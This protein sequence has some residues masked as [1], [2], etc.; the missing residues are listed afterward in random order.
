MPDAPTE[1]SDDVGFLLSRISGDILRDTNSAL[2]PLGLRARGFSVLSC[3][4]EAGEEYTQR[5]LAARLGLDPSQVV[6]LL[7]DLV[8]RGLVERR[9]GE[10]DRRT[11]TVVATAQGRRLHR[12]AVRVVAQARRRYLSVLSEAEVAALRATLTRLAER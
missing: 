12:E 7:D 4:A 8:D 11:R 3:A 9:P 10:Q 6:A 1:L 5:A 2:Q